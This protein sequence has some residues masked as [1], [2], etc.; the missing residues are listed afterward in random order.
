MKIHHNH[1]YKTLLKSYYRSNKTKKG[2]IQKNR[3]QIP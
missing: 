2:T 3:K 1:V